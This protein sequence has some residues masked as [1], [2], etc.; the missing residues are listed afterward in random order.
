[1]KYEIIEISPQLAK[2]QKK[3]VSELPLHTQHKVTITNKSIFDYTRNSSEP[4]FF[5]AM[6]VLDNLSHDLIRFDTNTGEPVQG[7]VFV[8]ESGDFEQVYESMSDQ[9]LMRYLQVSFILIIVYSYR[10][11]FL[12]KE[13]D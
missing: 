7:M 4:C 8:D 1:M 12:D 13:Q 5:I 6:E 11:F 10:C 3:A 2:A 9:S